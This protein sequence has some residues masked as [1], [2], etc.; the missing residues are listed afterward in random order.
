MEEKRFDLTEWLGKNKNRKMALVVVL[1]FLVLALVVR[2]VSHV[3][4]IGEELKLPDGGLL[5]ERGDYIERELP[6]Y[7]NS[8]VS[9][10]N[11]GIVIALP[12]GMGELGE[13]L[14]CVIGD[15]TYIIGDV[16]QGVD[17][18][19]KTL[20][21]EVVKSVWGTKDKVKV[22]HLKSG[23]VDHLAAD[24]CTAS[25]DMQISTR[26]T[27]V[28]SIAY[29]ISVQDVSGVTGS[30][31]L[32]YACSE[33]PADLEEAQV[34]LKEIAGSVRKADDK[35]LQDKGEQENVDRPLGADFLYPIDIYWFD[36]SEGSENT[37]VLIEWT[38]VID[39]P[40]LLEVYGPDDQIGWLNE[41][42]S[43]S[44]HYLYEF[45]VT[46][47]GEYYIHGGTD[48]KLL[49]ATISVMSMERYLDL[50]HYVDTH[51]GEVPDYI[52]NRPAE[53]GID[54]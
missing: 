48:K 46:H 3:K 52:L 12:S 26:K 9:N 10:Q 50:F 49:G 11:L 42:Y 44:G 43:M 38:N 20:Y 21:K 45:G 30:R 15:V 41:D 6:Y 37:V 34:I 40:G 31:L 29:A 8:S 18:L 24:F 27:T 16:N 17:E 36:A 47:G 22:N 19:S 33:N 28:Y 23:Y 39:E 5:D 2:V 1:M 32:L 51:D 53:E 35:L 13:Y 54:E 14:T 25:V 4:G 7:L